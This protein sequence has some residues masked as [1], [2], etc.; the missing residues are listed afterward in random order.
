MRWYVKG[1]NKHRDYVSSLA[2]AMKAPHAYSAGRLAG[3][4]A[5]VY[6]EHTSSSEARSHLTPL[7]QAAKSKSPD[8]M[9]LKALQASFLETNAMSLSDI[10][11]PATPE[12]SLLGAAV[13]ALPALPE[14]VHG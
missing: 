5:A 13:A 1:F 6:K 8:D 10:H 11:S 2:K 4:M 12:L 14:A 7:L 3:M 9:N